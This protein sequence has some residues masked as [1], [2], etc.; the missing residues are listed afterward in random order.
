MGYKPDGEDDGASGLR[1][2]TRPESAP[3]LAGDGA[4]CEAPLP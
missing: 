2:V 3:F 4:G 1:P